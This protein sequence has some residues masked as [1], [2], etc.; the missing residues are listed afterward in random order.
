MKKQ[1]SGFTLIELMIV[2]AIIGILAA[3]AIPQYA[4]YTQRTKL[5]GG[6]AGM[7]AYKTAV[8]MCF[9]EEGVIANCD[10]GVA[11]AVGI[12]E[13]ITAGDN[14][15]TIN[16]VD[17]VTVAGGII[18]VSTTG[19]DTGGTYLDIQLDPTASAAAGDAALNWVLTGNGCTE[20]GRSI[21]CDGN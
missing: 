8:A 16:Y 7:V 14:G 2:V 11:G 18:Q 9:Q 12:P 17:A 1:Q 21:Q 15:A 10:A 4:D 6:V 5:A 13:N 3:I 20:V 19:V